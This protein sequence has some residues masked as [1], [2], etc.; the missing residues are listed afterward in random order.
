[1]GVA[2]RAL[3]LDQ[4]DQE[5]GALSLRALEMCGGQG[6]SC[7][8]GEEDEEDVDAQHLHRR[9][10]HRRI[11]TRTFEWQGAC[12]DVTMGPDSCAT[13]LKEAL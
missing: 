2:Y 8:A 11:G 13:A 7:G 10:G 5:V 9:R 12:Q 4:M 6:A 3:D 1:M